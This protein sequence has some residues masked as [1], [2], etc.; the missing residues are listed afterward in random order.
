MCAGKDYVGYSPAIIYFK[1]EGTLY[2]IHKLIY[3]KAEI[4]GTHDYI[5]LKF[6]YLHFCEHDICKKDDEIG[7]S[8]LRQIK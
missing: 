8:C 5:S 6:K 1:N 2:V 3:L 4:T 7:T